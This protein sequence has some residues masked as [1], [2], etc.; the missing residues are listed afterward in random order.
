MTKCDELFEGVVF[1]E[2]S[3][4]RRCGLVWLPQWGGLLHP[5]SVVYRQFW[6]YD[7][8]PHS[9]TTTH[10]EI[11][12]SL[13][14]VL[15]TRRERRAIA[16]VLTQAADVCVTSASKEIPKATWMSI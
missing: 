11:R 2:D 7:F 13:L 15:R 6:F 9:L 8:A 16:R 5:L 14:V 1:F 12:G 3:R 4:Q 10:R